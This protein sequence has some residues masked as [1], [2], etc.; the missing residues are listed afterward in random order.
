KPSAP[1]KPTT[2]YHVAVLFGVVPAGMLPA[3]AQLTPYENLK[4]LRPLP[5]AK[6]PLVVFRG[7]TSGGK[8]ATFTLVGE[9]ILHGAAAC[10]PRASQCQ[11]IDLKPSQSEQLEYLAP[12]GEVVTYELRVV[13]IVAGKASA[14]GV[15]TVLRSESKAGREL[16]RRAGL[17]AVPGLHYS[18]VGVLAFAAHRA[19][20]AHAARRHSHH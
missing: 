19:F 9:A 4:L 1:A 13:S 6:Q 18:Q 10:L 15:K 17:V 14:A 2:V 8:S 16:L 7:V 11:A 20:G 3:E 12:N 5:S